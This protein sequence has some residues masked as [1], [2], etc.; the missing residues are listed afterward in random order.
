MPKILLCSDLH[1]HMHKNLISRLED[2]LKVVEW[3][4]RTAIEREID[5]IVFGGDL[6]QDR[7]RI[8]TISYEKTFNLIRKFMVTHPQ[9]RLYLLVGNHDMWF[10]NKCDVSSISPLEAIQGVRV[11]SNCESVEVMPGYHMDFLP[12]TKN[13]LEDVAEHFSKKCDVLISHIAIDDAK[14]NSFSRAEVSVEYDGDMVKVDIDKFNGWKRV[15]LGHYHL[16]QKLN[17]VVEYIGSPYELN[18]GE[19]FQ[20]KHI[21]IL[22]TE[23][24]ETEY[25]INDFSPKH[26]IIKES[27]LD[28]YKLDGNFVQIIVDDIT[29]TNIVDMRHKIANECKTASLEFKEKKKDKDDPMDSP[30]EKFDFTSGEVLERYI[31]AKGCE[32]LDPVKLL[33]I[34]KDI[35]QKVQ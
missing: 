29:S 3:I 23:S 30:Q 28:H 26:L 6:Y 11:I 14:L 7:Q 17:D 9:L 18:F 32:N 33:A 19:A 2:G 13:P 35:C 5:V 8:H 27:K 15:F 22:D 16:A 31:K 34:G 25:V 20:E 21:I 12:Y 4:F 1:I 24:L 10:N